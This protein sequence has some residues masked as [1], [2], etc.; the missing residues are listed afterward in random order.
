[1][2]RL[3]TLAL[4]AFGAILIGTGCKR[5]SPK[6][7]HTEPWLRHPVPSASPSAAAAESDASLPSTRYVLTE[8]SVVRVELPTANGKLKGS[9]RRVT[10]ELQVTLGALSQ[11]HG[12]VRTDLTSLAFDDDADSA[13]WLARVRAAL[14]LPDSGVLGPGTEASFDLSALDDPV[15]ESIEAAPRPDGGT[16][17]ARRVRATAAGNLLLHGFRVSKRLPLEAEFRFTDRATLPT[18]VV[19]RTRGSFVVSLATH[20]IRLRV[21]SVRSPEK[22]LAEGAQALRPLRVTLELHGRKE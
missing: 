2:S 17:S 19:I 9:F 14:D 12:Q 10:G 18:S 16:P 13:L 15:P 1:L 5:Q 8:E 22:A 20:E 11:S 4:A 21:P 7:S 6:P 3:R